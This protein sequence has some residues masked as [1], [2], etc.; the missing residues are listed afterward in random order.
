MLGDQP[1]LQGLKCNFSHKQRAGH[2]LLKQGDL[3]SEGILSKQVF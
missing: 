1:L 3:H 2:P